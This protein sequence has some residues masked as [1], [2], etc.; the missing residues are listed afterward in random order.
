MKFMVD[1]NEAEKVRRLFD[2]AEVD[3]IPIEDGET[4][5]L[6]LVRHRVKEAAHSLMVG[7]DWASSYEGYEY[8]REVCD[9]LEDYARMGEK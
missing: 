4:S 9:K 6:N 1:D 3:Y 2:A 8:W 5:D 7:F